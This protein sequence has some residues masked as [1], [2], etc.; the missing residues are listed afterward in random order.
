MQNYDILRI[1]DQTPDGKVQIVDK[2]R[3]CYV[4]RQ[5]RNLMAFAP[6]LKGEGE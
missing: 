1:G 4:V 5:V 3:L 2:D 6:F